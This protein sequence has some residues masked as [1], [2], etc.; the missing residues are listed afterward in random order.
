MA[1]KTARSIVDGLLT[2][3]LVTGAG[4][5]AAVPVAAAPPTSTV[6]PAAAAPVYTTVGIFPDPLTCTLAGIA[7]GRPFHCSWWFFVW[8]LNVA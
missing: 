6:A 1:S 7:T 5:A 2:V 4:A 8:A 3:A